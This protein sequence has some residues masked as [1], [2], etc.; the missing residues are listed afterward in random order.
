[1]SRWKLEVPGTPGVPVLPPVATGN[2]AALLQLLSIRSEVA[3]KMVTDWA[4]PMFG[5]QLNMTRPEREEGLL[6]VHPTEDLC[7]EGS[8]KEVYCGVGCM[9][10][11][12]DRMGEPIRGGQ[13][14]RQL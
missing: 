5:M 13:R 12:K 11:A 9:S 14:R 7:N 6:M 2:E 8:C 1:M 4:V 3:V 10:I